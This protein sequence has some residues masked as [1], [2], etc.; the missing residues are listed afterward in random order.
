MAVMTL[1][2]DNLPVMTLLTGNLPVMTPLYGSY[3]PPNWQFASY[4][5]PNLQFANYDTLNWQFASYDP[6]HVDVV[7]NIELLLLIF[8]IEKFVFKYSKIKSA[9]KKLADTSHDAIVTFK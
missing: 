6:P 3:D 9:K 4:D 7:L 1:L 8:F 5:L 2:T